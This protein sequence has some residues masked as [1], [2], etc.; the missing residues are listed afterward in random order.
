MRATGAPGIDEQ[1]RE[2]LIDPMDAEAVAR[3]FEDRAAAAGGP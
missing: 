2:R 1:V 3:M